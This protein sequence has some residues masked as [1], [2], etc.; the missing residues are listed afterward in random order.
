MN[1]WHHFV[2]GKGC[3]PRI[4]NVET[5]PIVSRSWAFC[6]TWKKMLIVYCTSR[7]Q[8]RTCTRQTVVGGSHWLTHHSI[9]RLNFHPGL[10]LILKMFNHTHCTETGLLPH[11]IDWVAR[12][13]HR[14]DDSDSNLHVADSKSGF[15]QS[16]VG[17]LQYLQFAV[18]L[19]RP[20]IPV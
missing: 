9:L 11:M 20:V 2:P 18:S 4:W 16:S 10:W 14:S 8:K 1:E 12:G 17:Q 5:T 13:G 6:K 7:S 15:L 19:T 3:Q